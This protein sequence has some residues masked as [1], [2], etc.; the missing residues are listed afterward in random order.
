MPKSG[1]HLQLGEANVDSI[2]PGDDVQQQQEGQQSPRSRAFM[3]ERSSS[4][5]LVCM[6]RASVGYDYGQPHV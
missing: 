1:V 2:E 6:S 4:D 5:I 3:V